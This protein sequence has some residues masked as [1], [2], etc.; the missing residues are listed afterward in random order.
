M[1]ITTEQ[2]FEAIMSKDEQLVMPLFK[3]RTKVDQVMLDEIFQK[4]FK[5]EFDKFDYG[6]NMRGTLKDGIDEIHFLKYDL[7]LATWYHVTLNDGE[8]RVELAN[9][10]F[11]N[12]GTYDEQGNHSLYDENG[13]S[14]KN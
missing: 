14:L 12:D 11:W 9:Q 8:C 4:L 7:G 1:K 3:D 10:F 5:D 6:R 13:F 2:L